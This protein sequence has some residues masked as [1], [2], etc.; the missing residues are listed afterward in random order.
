M[1]PVSTMSW[2]PE[3]QARRVGIRSVTGAQGLLV[4]RGPTYSRSIWIQP[5]PCERSGAPRFSFG[6]KRSVTN[7]S[8]QAML[9]AVATQKHNLESC[10][11]SLHLGSVVR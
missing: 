4:L 9:E 5:R 11:C 6:Q 1:G 2:A 3:S 10:L 8:A 7:A